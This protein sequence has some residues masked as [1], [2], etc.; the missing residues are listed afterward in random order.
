MGRSYL[1]LSSRRCLIPL[2]FYLWCLLQFFWI[3]TQGTMGASQAGVPFPG[4]TDPG[5]NHDFPHLIIENAGLGIPQ[6]WRLYI[7]LETL[8]FQVVLDN[9]SC[10]PHFSSKT[11]IGITSCIHS[12]LGLPV[13]PQTFQIPF[14][15][16]EVTDIPLSPSFLGKSISSPS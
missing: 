7:F 6:G 11:Y 16:M 4:A 14:Y 9:S 2:P 12:F 15:F 3:F 1:Y 13:Q 10:H 8:S 5:T